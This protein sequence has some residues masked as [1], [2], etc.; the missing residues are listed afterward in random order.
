MPPRGVAIERSL[1]AFAIPFA[2][3]T[4]SVLL[5]G[6]FWR[7]EIR[8][9]TPLQF[10]SRPLRVDRAASREFRLF[11][12]KKNYGSALRPRA[13]RLPKIR[14]VRARVDLCDLCEGDF[15]GVLNNEGIREAGVSRRALGLPPSTGRRV[16]AS[17]C[18]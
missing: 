2:D 1:S 5:R 14:Y 15:E 18:A 10:V 12:A 13:I 9:G 4:P 16:N 6:P 3:V 17:R 8:T 7:R 11:I